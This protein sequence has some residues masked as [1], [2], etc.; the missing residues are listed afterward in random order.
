MKRILKVILI[1]IILLV[2][3]VGAGAFYLSS[4]LNDGAKLQVNSIDA[5]SKK[6]GTYEGTYNGG[7]WTNKVAVTVKGG[8]IT[9]IKIIKD[10]AFSKSDVT[11]TVIKEV[12]KAQNTTVDAVSGATVT[13]KAYLKAIENALSKK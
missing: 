2:V 12:L 1:I 4:G 11:D 8:K 7:R 6:D 13:S 9:D 10:V 3:V 5:S